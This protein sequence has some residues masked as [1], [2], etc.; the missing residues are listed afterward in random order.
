MNPFKFRKTQEQ[1]DNDSFRAFAEM[2]SCNQDSAK[3]LI[4]S[5]LYYSKAPM[6]QAALIKEVLYG[7][8]YKEQRKALKKLEKGVVGAALVLSKNA[9]V[10]IE[11]R[12]DQTL[13]SL[14]DHARTNMTDEINRRIGK[15]HLR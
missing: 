4:K 15:Q 13:Y 11:R 1:K 5:A 10:S 7:C 9:D 6:D 3:I 12:E 14:T 8:C 2:S